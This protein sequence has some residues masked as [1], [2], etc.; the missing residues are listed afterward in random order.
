MRNRRENPAKGGGRRHR[1]WPVPVLLIAGWLVF[2]GAGGSY[3]GML[4]DV[5]KNDNASFLPAG[6]EATQVA[7]IEPDFFGEERWPGTSV[8]WRPWRAS[9]AG[10]PGR[11]RRPTGERCRSWCPCRRRGTRPSCPVP[12]RRSGSGRRAIPASPPMSPGRGHGRRLRRHLRGRRRAAAGHRHR[13]RVHH[14][15]AGLPQ[16]HPPGRRADLGAAGADPSSRRC[17][18]CS[19]GSPSGR[20]VPGTAPNTGWSAASG[21]GPR[22]PSPGVPGR[23]GR[24]RRRS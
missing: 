24:A 8:P 16:R 18:P 2:L 3:A 5:V 11:S 4:G 17:S 13:R 9:P 21:A 6:A 15:G 19:A 22:A 20:C 14:P 10:Y 23:Y 1:R 7:R 12:W